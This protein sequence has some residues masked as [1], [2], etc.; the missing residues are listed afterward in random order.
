MVSSLTKHTSTHIIL[1]KATV[2]NICKRKKV[3]ERNNVSD[4]LLVGL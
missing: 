4:E 2:T 3:K 1:E